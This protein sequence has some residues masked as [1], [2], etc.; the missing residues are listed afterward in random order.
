MTGVIFMK[1]EFEVVVIGGGCIGSSVLFS[2]KERGHSQLALIDQGRRTTSATAQSGG[3]LRIFH[4]DPRHTLL[5]TRSASKFLRLRREKILSGSNARSGSLYFFHHDRSS[6]FEASLRIMDDAG[7]CF[8]VIPPARGAKEFPQF[9]W[10]AKDL[11]VYESTGTHLDPLLF[12]NELI[13]GSKAQT[14]ED[15]LV[16][17]ITYND[18]H[19]KF[20]LGEKL[21]VTKQLVLAGGVGMLPLLHRLQIN[22]PLVAKSIT[23]YRSND[24]M[25]SVDLCLPNYFDRE[26]LEYGRFSNSSEMILSRLDP[27]RLKISTEQHHWEEHMGQDCYAP[28]RQG[29]I[30]SLPDHPHL[31]VVS[32]WGGTGL[33]FALEIGDLV[34]ER[35]TTSP[36]RKEM[37]GELSIPT[38]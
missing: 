4:E 13:K 31:T 35:I 27:C 15:S 7:S 16:Q 24:A 14:F 36:Q 10:S 17:Q 38:T 26:T 12:A 18:G 3:M 22:L 20:Q 30:T 34:A 37:L 5:A 23:T 6:S 2:L 32:G 8:E 33:K 19:Y 29:L 9:N 21:I 25:Q 28:D 11:A 1:H